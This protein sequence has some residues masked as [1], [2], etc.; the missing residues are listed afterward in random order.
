MALTVQ[1]T[2]YHFDTRIPSGTTT[3]FVGG[4]GFLF[5]TSP[6][7]SNPVVFCFRCR[8]NYCYAGYYSVRE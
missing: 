8:E 2:V 7:V 1:D 6:S 4:S 5:D 3:V